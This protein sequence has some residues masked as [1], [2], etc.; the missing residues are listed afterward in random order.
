[1]IYLDNAATTYP[2]PASVLQ[3]ARR[4]ATRFGANPGRGGYKMSE[5]TAMQVYQCRQ[6]LSDFFH[7][8]SEE[9]VCFTLN[10]TY[11]VNMVVK[12]LLGKGDHCVISSLDH[13]AVSRT[14]HAMGDRGVT[15]DVAQVD[16]YDDA[17]TLRNFEAAIKPNTR[18]ICCTHASNVWGTIL[19]VKEIGALA[20]RKGILFAVDCAQ[21]AGVVPIDMEDM[22]I[23]FLCVAGHKGLY[24]TMG[25]GALILHR[26]I[27]LATI[28]EGGTGSTSSSLIQP[29]F[30][31]DRLESGTQNVGGICA[32]LAGVDFVNS[33]GVENIHKKE[34]ALLQGFYDFMER[35]DGIFL[36]TRRPE[37]QRQT[38]VLSFN[39]AGADSNTGAAL[40]AQEGIAVRGGLQCAPLAHQ[41][42]G[43]M[44]TG[45]V[46]ISPSVFSTKNQM[47]IL[48]DAVEKI[49]KN[50]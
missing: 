16:F 42:M 12:G 9:N 15:Y 49:R 25:V 19:P 38:A 39:F 43:T 27:P 14:I 22:N 8:G 6:A 26:S 32:L 17:R 1:M 3:A 11:A 36:Y 37:Q 18:L 34:I 5:D 7:N 24:S 33:H 13:N 40:L 20:H 31:P 28:I 21:S 29:D 41:A 10:C 47:D 2:K 45:T 35:Q 46:R 4:S 44:D 23:D 48:C 30:Y 50:L